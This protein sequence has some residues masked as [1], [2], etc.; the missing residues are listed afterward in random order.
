[1]IISETN[2]IEEA[3]HRKTPENHALKNDTMMFDDNNNKHGNWYE[4]F[5]QSFSI[6]FLARP[7]FAFSRSANFTGGYSYFTVMTATATP[8]L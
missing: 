2:D 8:L 3:V 5:P 6:W 4:G 7:S 1:M